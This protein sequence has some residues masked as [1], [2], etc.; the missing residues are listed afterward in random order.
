MDKNIYKDTNNINENILINSEELQN[1]YNNDKLETKSKLRK[2]AINKLLM[3]KAVIF[4]EEITNEKL[5][6]IEKL[7]YDKQ[8]EIIKSYLISNNEQNVIKI[9]S[10]IIKN[11]CPL[12]AENKIKRKMLNEKIVDNIL[13]IF[14]TTNIKD[15]FSLCSSILSNICTDYILFSIDMVHNEGGIKKVYNEL[16]NK[17]FDNPYI[18]SNCLNCYKEGLVHLT[19]Q[20]NTKDIND[21]INENVKD[22]S[23]NSKR[24]LCNLANW[25]LYNKQL[26]FS[27]PQE[28]M[29][30]LFKLLEL[31]II[32]K[33]VPNQYEMNFDLNYSNNNSYNVHFEN[34]ILYLFTIP[35]QN[36][37]YDTYDFYLSLLVEISKKEEY[38]YPLTQS[39][40]NRSIFDLLKKLFGYIYLN[41]N[42]TIEER[43]NNPLLESEFISYCFKIMTNLIKET[44]NHNDIMNLIFMIFHNYRGSVKSTVLV[45]SSI[46]GFF[47]KLSENVNNNKKLYDFIFNPGYK[48]I[49]DCIKFYVR[50]NDCFILVMQFL[51][52][53]FEVRNF[54]EKE[55]VNINTVIKCI[56]NGLDFKEQDIISTSIKCL[57]RM[58][59]INNRKKYNIDLILK[60]EENQVVEKINTL[61]LNKNLS[62]V[63][64]ENAEDL[65]KYIERKIK[66][67]DKINPI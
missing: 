48:I 8:F 3:K 39:Y 9:L 13:N 11:I 36:I 30:S 20:I 55:N 10:Y 16:Q 61:I 44:V 18:I 33:S 2:K 15:I 19:E 50:N 66:D 47:V 40:N 23:Y 60:F 49:N 53:L 46:M 32:I 43:T 42:S 26:F 28:G 21:N 67:E 7:D 57:E 35:L 58:I 31:L 65:I 62:I 25:I 5:N 12:P 59:E 14:Y 6:E 4:V 1:I 41:N 45:P 38:L 34:L 17:Y 54:N 64:E 22:I 37:E 51:I 52:N 56:V 63:D 29:Q 24:L 27:L